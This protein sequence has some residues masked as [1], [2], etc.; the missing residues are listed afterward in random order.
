MCIFVI[1]T[2]II[3][4][5]T[6]MVIRNAYF[7][8]YWCPLA[9]LELEWKC[10]S[11]RSPPYFLTCWHQEWHT[12]LTDFPHVFL[13]GWH[14]P[15]QVRVKSVIRESVDWLLR[16]HEPSWK[17]RHDSLYKY[18]DTFFCILPCPL[19]SHFY[20]FSLSLKLIFSLWTCNIPACLRAHP[21]SLLAFP[22]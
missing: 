16:G 1:I 22:I 12:W 20:F 8:S 7:K 11:V 14:L 18:P 9:S 3:E 4:T 13:L 15:T 5:T 6:A 19:N 10:T 2:I 17:H 21:R